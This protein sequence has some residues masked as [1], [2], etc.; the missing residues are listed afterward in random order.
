VNTLGKAFVTVTYHRHSDFSLLIARHNALDK[1][2]VADVQ[3]IECSLS[4][5]TLG[6]EFDECFLRFTECIVCGTQQSSLFRW[7]MSSFK[8][9]NNS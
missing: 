3:F 5:V 1:E 4:I 8:I 2:D 9:E 7:W 6:K